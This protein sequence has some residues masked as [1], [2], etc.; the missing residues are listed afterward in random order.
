MRLYKRSDIM[1]KKELKEK[2]INM[3]LEGKTYTEIA[4]LTNWSRTY[5]SRLIED[6]E[7]VIRKKNT[8]KMK[9]HKRK[10]DNRLVIYIPT[11]YIEKLGISRDF[12]KDEYVDI[13]LDE[14]NKNIIIKKHS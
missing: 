3:F 14:K 6:D 12:N 7:R 4:K 5:I 11:A 9:V 10:D 1:D 8:R 13:K 2:C